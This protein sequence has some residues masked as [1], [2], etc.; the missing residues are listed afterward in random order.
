MSRFTRL[1]GPAAFALV[2][3]G[4]SATAAAAGNDGSIAFRRFL[5]GDHATAAIFSINPDG[6]GERQLTRPTTGQVDDQ[7]DWSRSGSRIV[8]DRC[9]ADQP[10]AIYTVKPDGSALRRVS[11]PCAASGPGVELQCEDGEAAAF[12]PDGRRFVYTRATGHVRSFG[13]DDDWIQNSDIVQRKVGGGRPRV[14]VHLGPYKGDLDGARVSPDGRWLLWTRTNS[15]LS[16]PAHA[17][18][19]F[20]ARADGS[21]QRRLTAWSLNAGDHPDWSP[22][23]KRI[24]FRT[25]DGDDQQSQIF[26]MRRDGTHRRALTHL[27]A[28][29]TV[30]S[31][32]FSPDGRSISFAKSGVGGE[33]DIFVMRADGTG[34]RP[35]TRTTAWDSAP[36][37]GR[38]TTTAAAATVATVVASAQPTA[39]SAATAAVAASAPAVSDDDGSGH[40]RLG[41][42]G[43]VAALAGGAGLLLAL[44]RRGRA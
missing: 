5:E 39:A 11:P 26:T 15:P 16:R 41:V 19:V 12:L 17:T 28:G 42:G 21:Q 43:G 44:R 35:V 18:A 29:T 31:Y 6:S 20:V 27:P 32:A 10:C 40:L 13:P 2:L 8:F 9:E 30:L 34:V 37:W 25:H 4:G 33:P 14:L 23:S 36:D 24:V 3:V 22:D 38:R 1:L 7:P